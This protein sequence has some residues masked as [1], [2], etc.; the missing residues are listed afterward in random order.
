MW[1][2]HTDS[3]RHIEMLPAVLYFLI[4]PRSCRKT[5][6]A[7]CCNNDIIITTRTMDNKNVSVSVL[8]GNNSDVRKVCI[9]S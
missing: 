1:F 8:S 5:E 7:V 6:T 3:E 4:A 9:K 2:F